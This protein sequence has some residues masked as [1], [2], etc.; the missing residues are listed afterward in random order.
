[1]PS[2]SGSESHFKVVIISDVF[3]DKSQ[4]QVSVSMCVCFIYNVNSIAVTTVLAAPQ[5]SHKYT[6]A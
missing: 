5:T 2:C 3:K 6:E 1:M 4:L